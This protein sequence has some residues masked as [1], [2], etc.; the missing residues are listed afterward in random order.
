[1]L[2]DKT[3]IAWE[4]DKDKKYHNPKDPKLQ[5]QVGLHPK[6]KNKYF[7]HSGEECAAPTTDEGLLQAD[8]DDLPCKHGSEKCLED[9][10]FMVWMRTAGLP[11]FRK[12]YRKVDKGLPKGD[13]T[14]MVYNYECNGTHVNPG[15]LFDVSGFG[16][17]KTVVVSTTAWIGGKNSFLGYAYITV[18]IVCLVLALVFAARV[19]LSP[20][21]LGDTSYLKYKGGSSD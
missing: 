15:T 17:H 4:A 16:G 21:P 12:L 7:N 20:R 11:N 1:M 18:G 6:F 3:G 8:L 10:D 5:M 14:V 13:Y 19:K 9:E 2:L